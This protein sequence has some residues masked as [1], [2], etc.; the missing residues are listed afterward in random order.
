MFLEKRPRFR[1]TDMAPTWHWVRRS[2]A[3]NL[4]EDKEDLRLLHRA[5]LGRPPSGSRANDKGRDHSRPLRFS[6]WRRYQV[7]RDISSLSQGFLASMVRWRSSIRGRPVLRRN[8]VISMINR[9][10]SNRFSDC[11][12]C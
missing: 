10:R 1:G 11:Y 6:A 3:K 2:R 4:P 9:Q 8:S 12:R 5:G 7:R